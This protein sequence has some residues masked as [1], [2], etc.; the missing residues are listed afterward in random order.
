LAT[1][2]LKRSKSVDL[3]LATLEATFLPHELAFHLFK[4]SAAF[5]ALVKEA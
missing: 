5:Q 2:A 4:I 1:L 3:A